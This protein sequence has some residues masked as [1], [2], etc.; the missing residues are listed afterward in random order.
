M[1][2]H[3]LPL[4]LTKADQC[5]HLWQ[6]L[7][8]CTNHMWIEVKQGV[9]VW[10]LRHV[11]IFHKNHILIAQPGSLNLDSWFSSPYYVLVALHHLLPVGP[12]LR[13]AN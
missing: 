11:V 3:S 1:Y 7:S 10:T 13:Q 6:K 9:Q 5:S 12:A 8:R 2:G 4:T